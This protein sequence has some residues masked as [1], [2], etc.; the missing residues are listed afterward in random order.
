MIAKSLQFHPPY[1][2]L[3]PTRKGW[4]LLLACLLLLSAVAGCSSHPYVT[5]Q[6]TPSALPDAPKTHPAVTTALAQLD[7]PY[8]YGGYTPQGFD[9]SGLV[10]YAYQHSGIVIP[11]TS[12][13]QLRAA[14]PIPRH[15]LAPGDLLFFRERKKRQASHVGLYVGDGRFVHASTS[16]QS[17]TLSLLDNPY[18]EKRLVSI[19][20][21]SK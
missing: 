3:W 6:Q 16:A 12:R 5:P 17:V 7:K 1:L 8:R 21:Y 15:E 2:R 19:G 13:E 10:Y 11:R 18:W 14:R 20:R 4:P 9:C